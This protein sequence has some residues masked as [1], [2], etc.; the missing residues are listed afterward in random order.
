MAL[1]VDGSSPV[2]TVKAGTAS[3][4]ATS[5]AFDPPANAIIVVCCSGDAPTAQSW[6]ITNNG[7][8]LTWIEAGRRSPGDPGATNSNSQAFYAILGA[9]RTGMTITATYTQANDTSFKIYVVTGANQTDPLGGGTEGSSTTASFS[10]TAYTSEAD[11]SLGFVVFTD[12]NATTFN[13]SSDTTF[14]AGV[15]SG[16]ISYG[17]GYEPI[18]AAGSSITHNI[19]MSGAP[20]LNWCSFEILPE[21]GGGGEPPGPSE[22]MI[23]VQIIRVP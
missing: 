11:G 6:T 13:G 10:T 19:Q 23:P 18:P 5:A 1:A 12:Y 21:S 2:R 9:A 14:D 7:A 20:M 17:S 8:A 3:A 4:V 15:I 16:Q 22:L